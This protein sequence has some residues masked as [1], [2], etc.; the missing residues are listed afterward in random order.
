[1]TQNHRTAAVVTAERSQPGEAAEDLF[2]SFRVGRHE[3]VQLVPKFR[4]TYLP[5][6][7]AVEDPEYCVDSI[8][9]G[10]PVLE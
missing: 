6:E 4:E 1:M 2:A 5:L 10:F 9:G 3:S 8:I 7:L